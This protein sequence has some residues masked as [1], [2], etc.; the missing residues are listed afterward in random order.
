M[1][2]ESKF[3]RKKI[4]KYPITSSLLTA[5]FIVGS[6][7]LGVW[8]WCWF[9]IYRYEHEK[10]HITTKERFSLEKDTLDGALKILQTI[11]GLGFF[12]TAY[13][14]WQTLN[15]SEDKQ[16]TERFGKAIELLSDSDKIEAR[17]GGIYLLERIAKDSP[18]DHPV[19]FDV[20]TAF[21]RER[22]PYK[23]GGKT[24]KVKADIQS[25]LTVIGRRE[26]AND[27]KVKVN[28]SG[29][30]LK[31]ADLRGARL[32]GADLRNSNLS[33]ADLSGAIFEGADLSNCNCIRT[34]FSNTHEQKPLTIKGLIPSNFYK[35]KYTP[36]LKII[37]DNFSFADLR[38][39]IFTG[40][41]LTNAWI[42]GVDLSGAKFEYA[43]L[44]NSMLNDAILS[45]ADFWETDLSDSKLFDADLTGA[46]FKYVK[47]NRAQLVDA[48][49]VD[50]NF[51]C[52][53]FTRANISGANFTKANMRGCILS[54]VHHTKETIL[55]DGTEL[56][57]D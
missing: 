9:T 24:L 40:A 21:V 50:S 22:S 47:L 5:L 57:L 31:E 42:N 17:I 19:V 7:S 48:I 6:V 27:G 10:I 56:A 36:D 29:A 16:V 53:D 32:T 52:A 3:S 20:L 30:N 55:P 8:G 41:D 13:I 26:S 2:E 38:N 11:G 37:K 34:Y 25:A 35:T 33:E 12:L 43:K 39:A 15:Q 4:F 44:F 45:K 46:K 28:L 23:Q 51:D 54:E 14:A 49:C 18:K 1:T